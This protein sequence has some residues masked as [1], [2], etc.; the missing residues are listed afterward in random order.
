[1]YAMN[2]LEITPNKAYDAH[3]SAFES[4]LSDSGVN[5]TDMY[6]CREFEDF[7]PEAD[8]AVSK[9]EKYADMA[10]HDARIIDVPEFG[11]MLTA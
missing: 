1:M 7:S 9:V 3:F 4:F 6:L 8:L 5:S 10:E 2:L 11:Y